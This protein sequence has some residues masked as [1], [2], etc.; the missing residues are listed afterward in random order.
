MRKA[1]STAFG[2]VFPRLVNNLSLQE[3]MS[4]S[5]HQQPSPGKFGTTETPSYTNMI[6]AIRKYPETVKNKAAG[7]RQHRESGSPMI[8]IM[9]YGQNSKV[10]E[11]QFDTVYPQV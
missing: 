6:K 3:K 2:R 5:H 10:P 4:V 8:A 11:V 1:T 9:K 7:L